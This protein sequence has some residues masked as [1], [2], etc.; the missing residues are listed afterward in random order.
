MGILA[1]AA[2]I[3]DSEGQGNLFA[4]ARQAAPVSSR[5]LPAP[6]LRVVTKTC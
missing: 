4:I 3:Q 1:V 2:G 6:D 5:R